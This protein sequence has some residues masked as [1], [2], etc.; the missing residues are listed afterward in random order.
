MLV[1]FYLV[2]FPAQLRDLTEGLS[3]AVG[4]PVSNSTVAP[5][6]TAHSPAGYSL[7]VLFVLR[8]VEPTTVLPL[9]LFF[10]TIHLFLVF[11]FFN[12]AYQTRAAN[13]KG[14]KVQPV[15]VIMTFVL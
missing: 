15:G 4:L 13:L 10:L 1:F 5:C 14:N 2:K 9:S 3:V 12:F 6:S 8:L 7:N 11:F